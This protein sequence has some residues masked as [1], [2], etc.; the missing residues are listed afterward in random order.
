MIILNSLFFGIHLEKA[1]FIISIRIRIFYI[2]VRENVYT[3]S[4]C[5][6]SMHSF[7]MQENFRVNM[8]C[9]ITSSQNFPPFQKQF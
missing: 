3:F 9:G 4:D 8:N 5:D 7:N 2:R 6:E 1:S